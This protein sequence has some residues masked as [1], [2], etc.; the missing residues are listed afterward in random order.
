MLGQLIRMSACT[1]LVLG[2]LVTTGCGGDDAPPPQGDA[3]WFPDAGDAAPPPDATPDAGLCEGVDC[4]A[5]TDSCNTGTCNA[6][7]GLCEALPMMDGVACN[8]RGVNVE[9]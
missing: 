7:T 6:D 2:L 8:R 1:G 3:N 4:S 9:P 5:M